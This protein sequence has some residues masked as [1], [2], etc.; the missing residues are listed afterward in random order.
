MMS[1]TKSFVSALLGIA[2]DAHLVAPADTSLADALPAGAFPSDAD[3]E[4]MRAVTIKDL[5]G[6]SALDTPDPPRDNSPPAQARQ[7]AFFAADNRARFA[8]GQPVLAAPG[9]TFLYTD[10]GPAIAS[11]L[12]SYAT[13]QTALHFAEDHLFGPLGFRN[14]EWMHQDASGLD[15]GGY[16]LRVRPIDMQKLGILYLQ[17]GMWNGRQLV[18]RA[19]VDASWTPWVHTHAASPEPQYGWYWWA[20]SFGPH[21]AAH[22][23]EGWKGQRIIVIPEQ[24]LVITITAYLE[25]GSEAAT[26]KRIVERWIAPAVERAADPAYVADAARDRELSRIL[27]EV[28]R[29]PM[30]GPPNPEPRMVPSVTRKGPHVDAV[31]W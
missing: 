19:W 14:Y 15:N 20:L 5:L 6:M 3:R 8:L 18:S 10:I 13:H 16:G 26:T 23:A 25:D 28:R 17:H 29:G 9:K 27:D 7:R 24:D 30:R 11:G 4:R 22:A 12:I 2:I 1:V 31:R 21:W